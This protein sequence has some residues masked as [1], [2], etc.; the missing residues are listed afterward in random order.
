M[1]HQ[2]LRAPEGVFMSVSL[3]ELKRGW[4]SLLQPAPG[5][6]PSA[7]PNL[8]Q[9]PPAFSPASPSALPSLPQPPASPSALPTSPCLSPAS[10]SL[11]Q[12]LSVLSPPGQLSSPSFSLPQGYLMVT[13]PTAVLTTSRIGSGSPTFPGGLAGGYRGL[14]CLP[15]CPAPS[16]PWCPDQTLGPPPNAVGFGFSDPLLSQVHS[17]PV[18]T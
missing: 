1:L 14:P 13:V 7:A 18:G 9:P 10:P 5:A 4:P 15:Q 6:S 16:C 2:D 8:P 3:N 17:G 11:L 12:P